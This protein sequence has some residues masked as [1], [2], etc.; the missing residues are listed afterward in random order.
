MPA[1]APKLLMVVGPTASGKSELALQLAEALN[2]EIISADSRTFYKEL[3]IGVAK[4]D[5]AD[6]EMA[7]HH[8]LDVTTIDQP[9][10]LGEFQKAST[11]IISSIH[12]KGKLPILVGGSGQYL[13]AITQGWQVPEN[14]GNE[15]MRI[16]IHNWGEKVGFDTL[17]AKLQLIDPGAAKSIDYRNHRRTIRAF[18]VLFLSGG[19][20]SEKKRSGQTPYDLLTIGLDWPRDQLYARVDERIQRMFEAGL[21][22]EVHDLVAAGKE[23]QLR[24]IGVIGYS[25]VLDYLVGE[26]TL[27]EC[28]QLIQR[29]TRKFIRHQANWFKSDDPAI[30]WFKAN[31]PE[32]YQ[33]VLGHVQN[34]LLS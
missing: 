4:P 18:E 33:K 22:G 26:L 21:V 31:D 12:F 14:V 2:G 25:E 16:A 13:R 34:W 6:R 28:I 27:E 19:R 32:R 29:N 9:W 10:S 7:P 1:K 30:H 24:R 3:T 5:R 17:Y 8:L 11:E 20:F 23:A 15:Y